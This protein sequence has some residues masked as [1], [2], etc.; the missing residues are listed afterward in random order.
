MP[1]TKLQ[2][3]PGIN[4]DNTSYSNEGGWVDC[5]NVRFRF[6]YPQK[7]G[8]WSYEG[9]T[10]TNFSFVGLSRSLHPWVALQGEKY[11]G[12]GTHRRLYI[13]YGGG[14]TNIT[15]YRLVTAAGAVTFGAIL[16]SKTL[17]VFHTGH[18]ANVGDWVFFSGAVGLGGII[19]AGL[20][21]SSIGYEVKNVINTNQYQIEVFFSA[22]IS[23]SGNGGSSVV[24]SYEINIG[25]N[26]SVGGLGWGA[27][28]WSRDGWGDAASS[29]TGVNAN[30]RL[31]SQDNYGEDL[32]ANVRNSKIYYWDK[33]STLAS[34]AVS[35]V[36]AP[37]TKRSVPQFCMQVMV[38]DR[39]RHVLAFGA[40]DVGASSGATEGNG[41]QD[42]LLVRFSS[43]ESLVDWWP[44]STNTA[45]TLRL[46]SG[47]TFVQAIETKREILVWTD[48]ALSSMRFIGPPFTFGIQQIAS[49]ITII[50]PNAAVASEDIVFWMGDD[51]FY[52]YDG[53]I[54]TLPCSVK[55]KVFSDLN[56]AEKD[57]I[58]A[59]L[60]SEFNEIFWFYPSADS[61]PFG[62]GLAENNRYVAYN[63][64]EKTWTFGDMDGD[65]TRTAWQDRGVA[66]YPIA[67]EPYYVT[68]GTYPGYNCSITGHEYGNDDNGNGAFSAYIE[69]AS[70]DI[71]DGDRF[72]YISRMIPDVT[73]TGS[74]SGF[75][76]SVDFTI[77]T[78]DY[79][80]S[81][82][83]TTVSGETERT[84]TVPVEQFTER[85]DL[86]TRGRSFALRLDS[87]SEGTF[88]KLG[89]PRVDIKP[90]GRR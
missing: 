86:R 74:T 44:E 62:T 13:A 12:V 77:K 89:N 66:Q 17:N 68:F 39:D 51:T 41:I 65:V 8:G 49:N 88:W 82:F 57:K 83:G 71:G 27:G 24:G 56:Y 73:F 52:V 80:G 30:L 43:Q 6:G 46:G 11:L 75:T 40:D 63:Y 69:S 19:S 76:P 90:D 34:R 28:T 18:G 61:D 79:P 55:T 16:G 3:Q 59:G 33:T 2:F 35:L 70:I 22:G 45:G 23:D 78:R 21:N 42:P 15:P 47:S 85:L 32:L 4:T 38:S 29:G 5:N 25:L 48:T 9:A 1:M 54:R 67:V 84:T 7:I 20:L 10:Y 14:N 31:W 50:S 26:S 36:D 81:N 72:A 60:N 64:A 87:G 58:V 53:K 37:G